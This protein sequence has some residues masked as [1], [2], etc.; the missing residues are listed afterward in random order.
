MTPAE[1]KGCIESELGQ[2]VKQITTVNGESIKATSSCLIDSDDCEVGYEGF[3][4]LSAL[5][6][7]RFKWR[8][9]MVNR[10]WVFNSEAIE[11]H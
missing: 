2:K 9:S 3:G 11:E 1:L 7:T 5:P 6:D 8:F 10:E 4:A